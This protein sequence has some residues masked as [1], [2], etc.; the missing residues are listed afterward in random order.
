MPYK[1]YC[2]IISS[3]SNVIMFH[4]R[5]QAMGN[6]RHGLWS[7]SRVFLSDSGLVYKFYK[8]LGINVFSVQNELSTERIKVPLSPNEIR[9]N[10]KRMLDTV[11][12]LCLM[13]DIIR[14]YEILEE[15]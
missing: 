14:M 8:D 2:D 7:G 11:S 6:V 12:R 10:R 1:E 15:K 9:L 13:K 5:Q 3:C 4:E